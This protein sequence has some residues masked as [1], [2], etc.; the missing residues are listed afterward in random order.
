MISPSNQLS[1]NPLST[2]VRRVRPGETDE[3]Y[4][5]WWLKEWEGRINLFILLNIAFLIIQLYPY[6]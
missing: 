5:I 2:R 3:V 4:D 6:F 1:D